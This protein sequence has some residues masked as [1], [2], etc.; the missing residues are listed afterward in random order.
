MKSRHIKAIASGA[1]A[2]AASLVIMWNWTDLR[3]LEMG[4]LSFFALYAGA[5][6]ALWR[7]DRKSIPAKQM[8]TKERKPQIYTYT[9]G[10]RCLEGIY[11]Q[12]K[13][14]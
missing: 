8:A 12:C 13:I 6:V 10:G 11:E 2:Q 3:D 7:M 4:F 14:G 1:F 5:A 9:K